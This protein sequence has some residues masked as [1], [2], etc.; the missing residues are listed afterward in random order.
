MREVY[1]GERVMVF[2]VK[3]CTWV[4]LHPRFL[5]MDANGDGGVTPAELLVSVRGSVVYVRFGVAT[6]VATQE[7]YDNLRSHRACGSEAFAA[8]AASELAAAKAARVVAAKSIEE[9]C[10]E[11]DRAAEDDMRKADIPALFRRIQFHS[12]TH[13]L[14]DSATDGDIAARALTFALANA[15]AEVDEGGEGSADGASWDEDGSEGSSGEG[16]LFE[17]PD[18]GPAPSRAVCSALTQ[19]CV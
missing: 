9:L 19:W 3:G 14:A 18:F 16:T 7:W 17:D 11:D 10:I 13:F 5:R 15:C 8:K 12:C 4:R 2:V 6:D 1:H